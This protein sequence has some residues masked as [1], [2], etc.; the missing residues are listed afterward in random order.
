MLSYNGRPFGVPLVSI[1]RLT[2][3]VKLLGALL[4]QSLPAVVFQVWSRT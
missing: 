2:G 3:G 1:A 4:G